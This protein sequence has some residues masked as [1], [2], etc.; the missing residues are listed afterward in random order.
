MRIWP[1]PN[2]SLFLRKYFASRPS[3]DRPIFLVGCGK[4]GTTISGVLFYLHPDIRGG[5]NALSQFG[6]LDN[7]NDLVDHSVFRDFAHR[8]EYKEIW[9]KYFPQKTKLRIGPE[10][11]VME[12]QFS[13]LREKEL[14]LE[15]SDLQFG[16][17]LFTK[18]PSN[19]FRVHVLRALFPDAYILAIHRDGRDV[20]SSWG[21]AQ[22][23]GVPRWEQFGGYEKAIQVFADKWKS[24]IDHIEAYKEELDIITYRYEDLIQ[25]PPT[26]LRSLFEQIEL[27]YLP[28]IY[29]NIELSAQQGAWRKRIPEEYHDLVTALT[30]EHLVSLGYSVD[31]E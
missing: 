31:D 29:D 27:P 5:K 6:G 9:D 15:L 30:R 28:E 10:L 19:T 11:I 26:V 7:I 8:M 18:F 14:K 3:F 21:K 17:R 12:N 22:K 1:K 13:A 23:N 24:A 20:I 4:S 25:S 16:Q 2:P